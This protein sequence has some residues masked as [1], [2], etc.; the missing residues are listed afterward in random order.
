[1]EEYAHLIEEAGFTVAEKMLLYLNE[2]LVLEK[3]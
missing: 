2:E 3:F 1:V